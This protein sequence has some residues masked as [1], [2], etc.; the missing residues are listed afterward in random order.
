VSRVLSSDFLE[1][2]EWV[3]LDEPMLRFTKSANETIQFP[4]EGIQ[5]YGPYDYNTR[6][7]SFDSIRVVFLHKRVTEREQL[8]KKINSRM[9][10]G[11]GYYNGFSSE[12]RLDSV[13]SEYIGYED[14]YDE[15]VTALRDLK[16]YSIEKSSTERTIV[17]VT[18]DDYKAFSDTK[19]YYSSKRILLK[20]GVPCQYL[21][22][23]R[24]ASGVGVLGQNPDDS[25]FAYT[26]WNVVL[27]SYAK[28]GGV[29]W[30]LKDTVAKDQSIDAIA[31]IRFA[32]DRSDDDSKYVIGAVT[33]FGSY[34]L[35]YGVDAHKFLDT[36]EGGERYTSKSKGLFVSEKD[37][38]KL[39][40][41]IIERYRDKE[42][43]SPRHIIIHRL[44]SFNNNEISGLEEGLKNAGIEKYAFI[45]IFRGA[46]PRIFE[47]RNGTASSVRRGLVL[48]MSDNSSLICTTGDQRYKFRGDI[49]QPKHYMGTP[50]PIS[51][52]IRVCNNSIDDPMIVAQNI[53][54]LTGLHWGCGWSQEIQLPITLD[55]A[56][57]IAKFYANG[58][59]PHDNLRNTS[60]FL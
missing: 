33:V 52:N 48:N 53:F 23:Y 58:V 12:F 28:V 36:T 4:I 20:S 39:A 59:I 27:S 44:G 9:C 13:V 7:R 49:K 21:S 34:G 14:D 19:H 10:E 2:P 5:K 41:I 54:N 22:R 15:M 60:W 47:I 24:G 51:A 1:N 16:R 6:E 40:E 25:N 26:I 56:H 11:F 18:G 29:P 38:K 3:L 50:V 35:L 45:E 17:L 43:E 37:S 55:F 31:G 32:R 46:N 42:G 30:V 57:K 8:M